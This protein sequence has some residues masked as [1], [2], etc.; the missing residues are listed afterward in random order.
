MNRRGFL[1]GLIGAS[2]A[3]VAAQFNAPEYMGE[4]IRQTLIKDLSRTQIAVP[5]E[6]FD[7]RPIW[8]SVSGV[9]DVWVEHVSRELAAQID[10]D[11]LKQLQPKI[12]RTVDTMVRAVDLDLRKAE[13]EEGKKVIIE[14]PRVRILRGGIGAMHQEPLFELKAGL[15][16]KAGLF[17]EEFRVGYLQEQI[18]V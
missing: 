3:A 6:A 2:A 10:A 12:D 9:K 8:T 4:E 16:K 11:A 14:V 5:G 18:I 7:N 13:V 17:D 1:K 15:E